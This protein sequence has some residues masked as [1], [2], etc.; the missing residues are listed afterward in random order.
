MLVEGAKR[1]FEAR[2]TRS[3]DTENY[4]EVLVPAS[5]NFPYI[6][7]LLTLLFILFAGCFTGRALTSEDYLSFAVM[8]LFTLLGGADLALPF[9]VDKLKIPSDM[10]QLYLVTGVVNGWFATLRAV[11][12]PFAFTVAAT[13]AATGMFRIDWR[14]LVVFVGVSVAIFATA[15]VCLRAGLS[16]LVGDED[17]PR[18]TLM[19]LTIQDQA[20]A[21]FRASAPTSTAFTPTGRNRLQQIVDRGTLRV[22]YNSDNLPFVFV[23]EKGGVRRLRHRVAT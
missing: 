22:G 11:M 4:V 12:N 3:N 23:N 5:F 19:H 20:P 14:R 6:G 18:R 9:L 2:E 16:L 1:L 7:K 8:G 13:C 21:V 17:F 10:Y 15:V